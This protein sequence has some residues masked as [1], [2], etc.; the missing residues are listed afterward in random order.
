V[1]KEERIQTF[2][3]E[4]DQMVGDGMVTLE[5]VRIIAYRAKAPP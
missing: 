2:L 3:P 1:D 5:K 4:L